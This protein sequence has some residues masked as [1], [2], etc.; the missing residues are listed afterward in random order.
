MGHRR[1]GILMDRLKL[2]QIRTECHYSRKTHMEHQS[3]ET[4]LRSHPLTPLQI[5][6]L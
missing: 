5:L 3:V 2:G 6:T 4:R 1:Q